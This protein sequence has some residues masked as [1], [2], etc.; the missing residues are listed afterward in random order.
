MR[1]ILVSTGIAA[2]VAAAGTAQAGIFTSGNLVVMRVDGSG[3]TG[4]GAMYLD[5]YTRAGAAVGNTIGLPTAG[6]DAVSTQRA[7]NHDRHLHLSPD[8]QYLT[9]TGYNAAPG[10]SDVSTT[11]AASTPRVVGIVRPS[12]T[13]DLSTKLTDAYDGFGFRSAY[14]TDG[15]KIWMAGDNNGGSG[16]AALTGGLRY[17]T[18]GSS[19]TTNLSQVQVTGGAKTPDNVRDVA[20][21]GGQL[22]D[23]SGSSSSIGKAVFRVGTGLP[24]SGSQTLTKLETDNIS[25]SSFYLLDLDSGIAGPDTLYAVGDNLYKYSYN[26]SAWVAKGSVPFSLSTDIFDHVIAQANGDGSISVFAAGAKGV[27]A[28]TDPSATGSLTGLSA[29]QILTAGADYQFGGIE[30]TP[31]PAPGGL[32]VL[33]AGAAFASR[34]R[35]R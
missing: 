17:T 23:S 1:S 29:T 11:S 24:E 33:L 19:T 30:F 31:S 22:F 15:T 8:G 12:G 18:K 26:G 13:V 27:I 25:K 16:A 5:E 4:S 34:R 28:V 14:T 2:L 20:A 32:G 3:A 21:F 35:S 7:T 6:A 10:A 9:F